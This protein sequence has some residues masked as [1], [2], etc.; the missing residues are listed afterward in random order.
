MESETKINE[1]PHSVKFSMN[2]KGQVSSE[3]KVYAPTPEEALK[4]ATEILTIVEVILK[5]KNNIVGK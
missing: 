1:S 3:L 4:K 5:E 2:A